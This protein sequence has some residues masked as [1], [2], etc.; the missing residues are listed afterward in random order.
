M[1]PTVK[2]FP[3][4]RSMMAPVSA[5]VV[6]LPLVPVIATNCPLATWKPSSIS[7]QS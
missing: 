7:D 6:V 4:A 2:L 3:N 1:L 5:V